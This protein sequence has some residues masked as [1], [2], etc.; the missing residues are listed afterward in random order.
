VRRA[1]L[2]ERWAGELDETSAR[3]PAADEEV[4]RALWAEAVCSGF[5][6]EA[7]HR[8]AGDLALAAEAGESLAGDRSAL[9]TRTRDA[10]ERAGA[11]AATEDAVEHLIAARGLEWL[12][13]E[14]QLL[15]LT[16]EDLASEAAFSIREDGRALAEVAAE[17]RAEPRPLRLYMEDAE[18][19]LSARLIAAREGELVGPL[20]RNEGFVLLQVQRKVPPVPADPD[21]HR[22]AEEHVL[23]RAVERAIAANVKWHDHP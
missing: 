18:G 11:D 13:V 4:R 23:A 17:C 5:L 20:R 2:R 15:E 12:R 14:G 3:F 7:A 8:L 10:A 1:L 21:V 19:D 22:K 16:G 9:F 6:E